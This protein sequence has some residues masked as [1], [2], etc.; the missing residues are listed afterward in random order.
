MHFDEA[1]I[2]RFPIAK[3]GLLKTATMI[4]ELTDFIVTPD[5]DETATFKESNGDLTAMVTD[6]NLSK[7]ATVKA[8]VHFIYNDPESITGSDWN[9]FTLKDLEASSKFNYTFTTI[10]GKA[11]ACSAQTLERL[12]QQ[13]L[14]FPTDVSLLKDAALKLNDLIADQLAK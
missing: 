12:A 6:H 4:V 7:S 10:E 14:P 1:E 13:P 5:R 3:D 8:N 11:E 2:A 9:V